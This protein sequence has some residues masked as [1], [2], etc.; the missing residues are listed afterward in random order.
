MK[1]LPIS[2]LIFSLIAMILII[3]ILFMPTSNALGDILSQGK[4]FIEKGNSVSTVLN[5]QQL[6]DTS[7]SIYNILLGVAI[8]IAVIVAMVLGIK[9]MMASA[10]EKGKL[11]EALIPFVVGCIVVFGSFAIWKVIIILGN[12]AEDKISVIDT[13]IA[14]IE[15]KEMY[16][17]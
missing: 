7:N 16:L 2:K 10:G 15:Y 17:R 1:N 4:D 6:I 9:F 12:N 14:N 3:N 13:R 11:K 8:G 5:E